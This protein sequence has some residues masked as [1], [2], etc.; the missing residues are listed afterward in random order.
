MW[1]LDCITLFC[2]LVVGLLAIG[3]LPLRRWVRL[4]LVGFMIGFAPRYC[5]HRLFQTGL[6]SPDTMPPWFVV[7]L[8]WQMMFLWSSAIL[9]V[10]W[11][12]LRFFWRGASTVV[13]LMCGAGVATFLVW[14]GLRGEVPVVEHTVVLQ[15]LPA[16]AEDLR[17]AVLADMHIDVIRGK[18]WCEGLVARVN[19]LQPDL[20]LFTGDQSDG[21][22]AYRAADLA[23]LQDLKAPLGK[24][25]ISGN[26]EWWF[27]ALALELLMTSYGVQPLDNRM[28]TLRGLTFLGIADTRD[29]INEQAQYALESLMQQLPKGAYPILLV[30][31]PGVAPIADHLGVKLQLSG[32][33]HGGQL[34]LLEHLIARFNRGFVRGWYTLPRGMSLFVAPGCGVWSGFPYRF[35]APEITILKLKGARH[36]KLF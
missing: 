10:V 2:S 7:F 14:S 36:G 19:A 4:L 27:D 11:W 16:E 29:L 26:H 13:P 12:G 23:P 9:T 34:P 32:H 3:P 31:K 24:Y 21:G 17:I 15:G 6:M 28:V 5:W 8:L 18:S 33:T 1:K 30:H 22:V 35:Y 20:I 25:A